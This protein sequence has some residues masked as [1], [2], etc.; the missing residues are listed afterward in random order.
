MN[1][2]LLW[3]VFKHGICLS[4]S[5][6]QTQRFSDDSYRRHPST[7]NMLKINRICTYTFFCS[8]GLFDDLSAIVYFHRWILCCI[9]CNG[10][11]WFSIFQLRISEKRKKYVM[12]C[13]KWIVHAVIKAGNNLHLRDSERFRNQPRFVEWRIMGK[14]PFEDLNFH[15]WYG[16]EHYNQWES[17][18]I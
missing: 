14:I 4:H 2:A 13:K 12:F 7:L 11:L 10:C 5:L 9:I 6:W 16:L 18:I 3:R 1:L 17:Q 8:L 15:M